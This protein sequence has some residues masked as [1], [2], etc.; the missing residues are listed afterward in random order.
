MAGKTIVTLACLALFLLFSPTKDGWTVG[1]FYYPYDDPNTLNTSYESFILRTRQKIG[2]PS[3]FR[4]R[5]S[6]LSR[7]WAIIDGG[8]KEPGLGHGLAGA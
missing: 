6:V 4:V 1:G 2:Y 8:L 3:Y 7:S 5:I